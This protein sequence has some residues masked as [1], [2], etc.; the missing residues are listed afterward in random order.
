M[1]RLPESLILLLLRQG[2]VWAVWP[3]GLLNLKAASTVRIPVITARLGA[4]G[5]ICPHWVAKQTQR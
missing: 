1:Y 4:P 3:V 2:L 5:P